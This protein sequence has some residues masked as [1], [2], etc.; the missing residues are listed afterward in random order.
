[1]WKDILNAIQS[2]ASS[3]RRLGQAEE[4]I[5]GL[6][7]T[8]GEQEAFLNQNRDLLR[9]VLHEMDKD[10]AVAVEQRRTIEAERRA[11]ERDYEN[12]ALRLEITMRDNTQRALPPG[13][14]NQ[15]TPEVQAQI[16]AL[17]EEFA[18]L[19]A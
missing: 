16:D 18:E 14:S 12:L 4:N 19:K 17:K 2:A 13:F 9:S 3:Y 1:M 8:A 6:E 10:R 7:E 11:A 15:N 5:K